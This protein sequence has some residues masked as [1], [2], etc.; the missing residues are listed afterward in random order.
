MKDD[1]LL[2]DEVLKLQEKEGYYIPNEID[3]R[4]KS[5]QDISR[6]LNE[7]TDSV[8]VSSENISDLV[9]FDKIRSFLK[10]FTH[11]QPRW[12]TRLF[13]IVLS[14]F[15]IE[16]KSTSDDL[17]ND[18]K[19][20]FSNHR[21]YLELYG[22]LIHWFL[23]S[24]EE[25]ATISKTAKKSKSSD[26]D[27]RTF[28]WS[29]Q[30]LKAFDTASWLLDL[31]LSK[32]W[33]MTPERI[34][35]ITLFTKPAYQL[36]ENPVNAKSTRVKERVFRILGLC[37]KYYDHAFVA[38]TTM[39]Q[40]L[41]YWEHS[42]EPMAEFLI[43]L[44]EKLNYNQLADEILR[45]VSHREFKDAGAKEVKDSPNPKTFSIFLT[46]LVDLSPKTILKN[47]SLLIHQLDSESYLMRSTM[48]DILGFMIED[49]SKSIEDNSNQMEQINGFFDILEER[50]LDSISYCRQKVLQVY[51]RLFDLKAKFPK[52]R[53]AATVLAIR[54]LQD[55]SSTVRK[56]VIRLLCKLI[57][58]HPYSMYGGELDLDDWKKRL[59]TL[60]SEI[61]NVTTEED[62]LPFIIVQ[63][64]PKANGQEENTVKDD[65]EEDKNVKEN[66]ENRDEDE[67]MAEASNEEGNQDEEQ[68]ETEV[69]K[70]QSSKTVVSAEKLQ[71]L[72]LMKAF[73]ED[74]IAFIQQ[75]H[76]CIPIITQLL[77]SKSK[78]EVL[79]SMNF[80]V[81]AYNY[82]VKI[83]Q[84]GI[85]KMLH[86][87]WTKDTSDEGK[88]IKMKLLSCYES[89]Y[90][91]FDRNCSRRTNVNRIAKNLISL[92]YDTNL[93]EL[94]S[95]EQLLKTVMQ[96]SSSRI[97]FEVIEKL[98]SVYGFTK[99]RIQ[100][101][102]RRGAII[103]LGML[104]QADTRIVSEKIDLML[105]IGLG[106]LGKSDLILARYTCIAL[107]RLQGVKGVEKGRGVQVGI[108]FPLQHSIF[109][110]LKDVINSPT[111]SNEWFSLA[112]QAINTVYLLCEHPETLCKE[113]IYQKTIKV[114]GVK[115]MLSEFSDTTTNTDSMILDYDM[116]QLQQNLP[117][118]QNSIH[119]SST[120][121][122]QLLFMV[123]HVALKQIV[124]LEIVESAWKNKKSQKDGK[125]KEP[126]EEEEVDELEQVGGTA[127]D[128]IG[129]AVIRIREREIL[130]GNQSLLARYGPLL[131]EV[132]AR[133]KLYNDRTLQVTATLAL[134]K[135]MCVSSEFC[136]KH[137]QLLFT[138]LEKSQDATIRSNIVIALGDMAVCFSTLIDD[139]ISFLYNRL[140][141]PDTL[142]K[143]NTV[144]VLT[145]LIL[146]GMVK[147]KGQ[148]SEMAKCLED[149]DQRIADLAKLF[150]TELASKDNA[151]YNNLPDII[152][153]LT[154]ANSGLE[155]EGFRRIMKFLFGF[156][157]VEK[158]KQA[159][160]IIDK[161]CQRFV[162]AEMERTWR[163]IAYCLSLLPY[164]SEKSM[165][166]LLEGWP[167]YQDK[168]H[169]DYV[170]KCFLDIIAKGRLQKSQRPD[171]KTMVDEL[172][173]KI[174]KV[175][176]PKQEAKEAMDTA[177]GDSNNKKTKTSVKKET[178]KKTPAKEKDVST[179]GV[180]RRRSRRV[181]Y[182][183]E[184]DEDI[185]E[186]AENDD[187]DDENDEDEDEEEDDDDDEEEGDEEEEEDNEPAES[188]DMDED[189][190]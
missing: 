149:A 92:T 36:F 62:I 12:L 131:V 94:T 75:I 41:Q 66:D 134:A 10:Y 126:R 95:L 114:F 153:N 90:L 30:K 145:H 109:T 144:M 82:Q 59:E 67:V 80:L 38:Q 84:E 129:D 184:S 190:S 156:D 108:R 16:I 146:N 21:H 182:D 99:G 110:R 11:I 158:E 63:P 186:Y 173:Q 54:H 154:M 172:D 124:H 185:E 17:E 183:E 91:E 7:I 136:E 44:V 121:L 27:L 39:M 5:D 140:S 112:E 35:F 115:E 31:K 76:A 86:L 174:E 147:V 171:M 120:E 176:G 127:E 81:I 4:G 47:I 64:T 111:E 89:L 53:Q 157:F 166:R 56:Y 43:Y 187:D 19:E 116:S 77:S 83:A 123:G 155:E 42:A 151:I 48:I 169:E 9:V 88:G 180:K 162:A 135:F 74:A 104:A 6:Y 13:D 45:D 96:S 33:T 141:D 73:H 79:E 139:N 58:T 137:L 132:C 29:N 46:K 130:Y 159:E 170:H 70:P 20:T 28:D 78:A 105:K 168:L 150:F 106:T 101:S 52:R 37:V 113:L 122:A 107:Q 23:I 152:S 103:I 117:F 71:Q 26:N 8:E 163:E 128:D 55:K 164:K 60:N 97:S 148:I 93:A 181:E 118:P 3:L 72:I 32:I 85:R 100:K 1:F 22:Y 98:W 188:M 51:L 25:N 143:K 69:E 125:G 119:Q 165:K 167:A 160:N 50:M 177:Q 24:A 2:S 161:L 179:T 57:S 142:V 14:A 40:N 34:T 15:R 189:G 68:K 65:N 18:Q 102:Q 178:K 175:R 49:L 87:I 138:I 61:E 133:N